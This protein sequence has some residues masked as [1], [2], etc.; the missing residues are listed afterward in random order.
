[1]EPRTPKLWARGPEL[2]P[3][4]RAGAGPMPARGQ[5]L[6]G[7]PPWPRAPSPP[8]RPEGLGDLSQL[9]RQRPT[10]G[11][12]GIWFRAQNPPTGT[13]VAGTAVMG[14]AQVPL[15]EVILLLAC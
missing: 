13:G 2:C 7:T 12:W 9:S 14:L 11:S 3:L 5:R 8:A 4:L 6:H 10:P 1:M 15:L